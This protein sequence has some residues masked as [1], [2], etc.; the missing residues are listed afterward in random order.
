MSLPYRYVR[1]V[2]N[3]ILGRNNVDSDVEREL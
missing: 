2:S 3:C 1:I